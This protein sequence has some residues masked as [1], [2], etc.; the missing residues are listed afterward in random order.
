VLIILKLTSHKSLN[1]FC[2]QILLRNHLRE[3]MSY[4]DTENIRSYIIL[5]KIHCHVDSYKYN[6]STYL[7]CTVVNV[8]QSPSIA[9]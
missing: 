5:Y 6:N 4:T 2:D 7:V 8:V 1:A 3:K 9:L